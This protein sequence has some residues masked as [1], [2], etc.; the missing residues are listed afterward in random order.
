MDAKLLDHVADQVGLE[1]TIAFFYQADQDDVPALRLQAPS[2]MTP[3][4]VRRNLETES[5]E[6]RARVRI[7]VSDWVGIT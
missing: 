2:T 4:G 1:S 3:A 6:N 5:G 7:A